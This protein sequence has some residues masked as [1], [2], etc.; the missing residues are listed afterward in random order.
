MILAHRV[1]PKISIASVSP[2]CKRTPR[3]LLVALRSLSS[4]SYSCIQPVYY[5]LYSNARVL[6][7]VLVDSSCWIK[8]L[9]YPKRKSI[10]YMLKL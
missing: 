2:V 4:K 9:S 5:R 6:F 3:R 8:Q 10:E 1:V 7:I